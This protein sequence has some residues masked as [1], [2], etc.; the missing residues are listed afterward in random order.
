MQASP[1]VKLELS[2]EDLNQLQSR[3][4][5]IFPFVCIIQ[6]ISLA[7]YFMQNLQTLEFWVLCRSAC[8]SMA[9][10][11]RSLWPIWIL[12]SSRSPF[13][14]RFKQA[15]YLASSLNCPDQGWCVCILPSA[16]PVSQWRLTLQ[17]QA[18]CF[19][20]SIRSFNF[21]NKK[22]KDFSSLLHFF[23]QVEVTVGK[24]LWIELTYEILRQVMGCLKRYWNSTFKEDIFNYC[25]ISV[26]S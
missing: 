6:N 11:S 26:L 21:I 2:G 3:E 5:I 22:N 14:P 12:Q 1:G 19:S 24:K 25:P 16:R 10:A 8:C 7:L 18:I 15:K 4:V 13:T 23:F 17:G 20:E 9:N